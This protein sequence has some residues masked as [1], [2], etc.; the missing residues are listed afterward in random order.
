MSAE[1]PV[2]VD[3]RVLAYQCLIELS[4]DEGINASGKEEIYGCTFGRDTA[5]T[6]LKILNAHSHQP[7]PTLLETSR[8][9]LLTL[10]SL[11]GKNSNLQSGEEPGK[12]I[13]EFRKERYEHLLAS[14]RPWYVYPDGILRNYDSI[15][16]T[17]LLL[18]A[19]HKY[20]ELTQDNEFL[21]QALPGVE[22]GLNWILSYG[23][24]DKD[25][26]IEF[27]FPITRK[28]GGL[29][30]QSWTDSM[31]SLLDVNGR[32]PKYPIAPIEAQGY[33]W[34][35]LRQWGEYY[36][37]QHPDFSRKLLSQ[38]E[39]LKRRFNETFIFKDRGY[40][41]GVQALD[42]DKNQIKTVTANPL[43]CLWA[44]YKKDG[45]VESIVDDFYIDDFVERVF[46][47]DLFVE[48]A[49]IR[50]MSS[51][52]LTFNPNEDSYHNGSI[53][54]MLN[55]LVEEGL[56]NFHYQD[57]ARILAMASLKPI[58]F[59]GKM[60]EVLNT[61]EGNFVLFRSPSGQISCQSQ[62]WTAA[63]VYDITTRLL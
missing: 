55:G 9:A 30:V 7:S 1:V 11:Q 53:W 47:P 31:E 59:F 40:Y 48:N 39:A 49:G 45:K 37:F 54:P 4:S 50:T 8:K 46:L 58:T 21:I 22:A 35:A 38:A 27:D 18:M 60:V 33:A 52:S 19:I 57:L 23:D 12:G 51:D 41:F 26:L 15:D 10:V 43:L 17:P 28:Y 32:M 29:A 36:L 13:H 24:I 14:E 34:L 6:V 42:G 56:E 16:S 61:S 20:W 63:A 44:A 3:L 62:A 5:I 2:A 25:L